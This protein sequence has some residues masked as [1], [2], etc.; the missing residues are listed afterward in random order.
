MKKKLFAGLALGLM[1]TGM[2]GSASAAPMTWKD[3]ITLNPSQLLKSGQSVTFNHDITD[4]VG[5]FQGFSMGGND[6][7]TDY[8]ILL[9]LHDDRDDW[10][11]SCELAWV[12]TPGLVSDGFYNFTA[13]NDTFGWSLAG[14]VDLNTAGTLGITVKSTLG[15]F[16]V[17]SS[18]L[19]ANGNNG[20]SA[21]VPEPA[22]MLLFGTGLAGLVGALRRK[23]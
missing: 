12:N 1:M 7:I 5:G 16:F 2:V 18:V 3:D 10:W 15:D 11:N 21:P 14:L 20:C 23:K 19:T 13:A 8:S 4:G 22:T 9:T 17:D 6:F